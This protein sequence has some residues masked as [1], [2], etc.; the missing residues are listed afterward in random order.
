MFAGL[1]VMVCNG[2]AGVVNDS[3]SMETPAP[4]I[5]NGQCVMPRIESFRLK[6]KRVRYRFTKRNSSLPTVG[7]A[8]KPVA[9]RGS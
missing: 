2:L 7:S 9:K 1:L 8:S 5:V 3:Q 6:P 4:Y